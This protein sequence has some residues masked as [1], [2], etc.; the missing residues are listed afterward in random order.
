[1]S[2][3]VNVSTA[4]SQPTVSVTSD[5]DVTLA[6][7]YNPVAT[8]SGDIVGPVA[9]T[10]NAIVRWNGTTGQVIQNSGITVADGASGTLSG[11]NSGD[12]TIGT[13]NGLSLAGQALSLGTSSASTTGALTSADWQTF[14]AKQGAGNYIT[15]LTGDVT[16]SGPGSVAATLA[17]TA[18]VPGA[19]TNANITV[20]SKGRITS[21]AN[22]TVSG[23]TVTSV[24]II[25]TDGIQV[26][27][28][29]PVTTSGDIQLGVDAATMKT[30]LNL[31]GTNTGD[32]NLFGTIAVAGQGNVVADS[33][34]D[35]LTLVAGSNI[36]ITTDAS[37]DSITINSTASG[38]GDVVGPA[39]S[40]D[41]ALVRF[42]STTGKLIQNG[43]ITQSDAG[44]LAAIN[45]VTFD[46]T[47]SGSLS[48]QG[49]A[50]WN[51]AYETLDIQLNGFAM[52]TGQHVLYHVKNSTGSPIAAGVPVMYAGTTGN[53]GRLL[54]QPWNGTGPSTYF[55]GLTA[56]SIG[57]GS[58]GFVIGFGKLSGIQTNGAN[59]GET[60]ADGD[61]IYTGT[62]SGSLTKTQPVAPNPYVQ[63]LA[64]V[65]SHASN[66]TVFIKPTLGSNIRAD[67]GVTITSLTSGQILV[68]NNAGT[69]FENKSVSGDAALSNTGALTLATVNSNVGSYGSAT[70][71]PAVT[72][73]AK[74]LVTAVSTNTIT[75]AVGSITG[76]GTGV[77]TAL[78]V[79]TG[80]SGA[81][82][83][84]GGALGTPS[85]G[86]LANCTS[87]PLSTGVTGDL[88]FANLTPATAASKLLGRGSAGG[89]GDFEEISIGSGL[90]MSGTTLSAT[91]SG[92][93]DV[94]G[95]ASS[96]N[97]NVVFFDG[98]T[99][100]LIKDSGLA[101]SG[102]NTGDVTLSGTP[103]YITISGQTITRGQIDLATDVTGTLPVA[104]GG[105]G[106]TALGTNV[107]TSLG[108]NMSSSGTLAITADIT[109]AAVGLSNVT[110]DAQTKAAIVPNTVPS[111][112][113][114]LVGNAGGTAYAA[115]STSGDATVAS[116]GAVTLATVNANVGSFG[117]ATAAPAFT[118]NAKGLI[119]AASTNTITPAVGSITGLGTGVAT[120]LAVNVG[121][122]GSPVVNGGALGTPS[123]GSLAS[124]T[125][126]PLSTGVTGDLPFANLTP[127]TA[128]SR[129]LGRGSASGA[130]DFEEITI[131][132]GL[133]MSGTTLSSSGGSLTNWTEAVSTSAPNATVPVVSFTA[134][135]AA[136]NVDAAIV[137]KGSGALTAQIA[138]SLASGGN[139]RGANAVDLQTVRN[140][141]SHVA[142]GPN[143]VISGGS[144]NTASQS[145]AA[146]IGGFNNTASGPFSV[147]GGGSNVANNTYS[148]ALC[149]ESNT[150][151][152][153]SA[154]VLAGVSNTAVGTSAWVSGGQHGLADR[155]CLFAHAAGRFAA[156]GDAQY[157]RVVLRNKTTNNT[158]TELYIDG[159]NYLIRLTIASGKIMSGIVNITGVKSDGSAVAHFL[160]QFSIK[161]VA[162]TTSAVYTAVTI[163]TDNAASTSVSVEAND[164]NDALRIYVTGITSE[165]WRWTASVEAVEVAYGT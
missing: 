128:A 59:Y 152:G 106:I 129:L 19:Y 101:L 105:T 110:D 75:P 108:N 24:G 2:T 91:G 89:A 50:M 159:G 47:P 21:A 32:Q 29:S 25:G 43:T 97:N 117:S 113:Q 163:G 85:S 99:G 28:G 96:V 55:M 158:Q 22:G 124:C 52:H 23:G 88:P 20:D 60:W 42:D 44:D 8:A 141:A 134:T 149:G 63:V 165:T 86:S 119:T 82:V 11:T 112:G 31:A 115:V 148:A 61:L 135:N 48:T 111:A 76:L 58:E 38:S 79:N 130:G 157:I 67:E 90:S 41:N 147:V 73:N 77:A 18:V 114:L 33:T 138:N 4:A 45:S 122:S 121:S 160:R 132:S 78:A 104:N 64:V 39:S 3:S 83:V 102:S 164:T 109:K 54:V 144:W 66:G 14:N 36:T 162:G 6:I 161:N 81:V 103:D 156:T 136:T 140:A 46:T 94:S 150:A 70:A 151:S 26:D 56:E 143:A 17:S 120:A 123:S 65:H 93:G 49:Q 10:D 1:M 40:T 80:S 5:G 100:K 126:L 118:V 12:V 68:A 71:A 139:K 13:A 127:A 116:T 142:S 153:Y 15:A 35:T 155:Q 95:P 53:S 87:L 133:S 154:A 98:T 146:V 74:G 72:V 131:G 30:T 145:N 57:N 51:S 27:S 7:A 84:N 37:T 34:N 69:V 16:A 9:S 107:A 125:G 137:P 62:T 92:S